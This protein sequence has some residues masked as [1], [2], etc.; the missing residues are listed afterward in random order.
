MA[1]EA[2]L[3]LEVHIQLDTRSK[4]FC[5]CPNEFAGE[6]N[7]RVCPVCLGLPGAL[8]SLN[9]EAVRAVARLGLALGAE[10]HARS[11]FARKNYF[12]PDMPKNY[13]ISQYDRPIVTGGHL[14]IGTPGAPRLVPL[15][16]VHLEEDTGKS[17]HPEAAGDRE[18]TRLDFNRC[19]VPLAEMVS[20]PALS[21]P[22]DAFAYLHA[23]RR[24]VRWLGISDGDMEKGS[25]RCDANVSLRRAGEPL[26]TRT[27]I[28]NLN[29]IAGVR[30]AIAAEVVRQAAVLDGGRSG[31]GK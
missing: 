7:T 4:L 29:S 18:E 28:K 25:L 5:S 24:L 16:R 22:D 6:P 21:S 3:G 8:P 2:V 17:S 30:N 15:T 12:Y 19:G 27:E 26:G 10:V 20:E 1:Y 11:V 23:L 13:Q 9:G 14:D 31:S